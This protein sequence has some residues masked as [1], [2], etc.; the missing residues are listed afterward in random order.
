VERNVSGNQCDCERVQ[1]LMKGARGT[2]WG[3][4]ESVQLCAEYGGRW[5]RHWVREWRLLRAQK[6]RPGGP[7]KITT[8]GEARGDRLH[9]SDHNRWETGTTVKKTVCPEK[10]L[11]AF[12]RDAIFRNFE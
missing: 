8:K 2:Q 12:T 10:S 4:E 7:G 11:E 3:L 5:R 1:P 9:I 6:K